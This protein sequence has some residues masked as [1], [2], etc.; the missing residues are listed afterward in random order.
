M[1]AASTCRS[2]FSQTE[3][4][5]AKGHIGT[6]AAGPRVLGLD[7]TALADQVDHQ[8]DTTNF[9]GS[10][11]WRDVINIPLVDVLSTLLDGG[12]HRR[13]QFCRRCRPVRPDNVGECADLG[14]REMNNPGQLRA[15]R[16]GAFRS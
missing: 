7:A 3:F 1:A 10:A 13:Q 4:R 15:V 2:G 11:H 12:L 14:L 16:A 9:R 8:P 6:L 5:F